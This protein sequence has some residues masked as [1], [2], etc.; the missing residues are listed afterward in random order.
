MKLLH[1]FNHFGANILT[2]NIN[3]EDSSLEYS[4]INNIVKLTNIESVAP[5]KTVSSTVTR[6]ETTSSRA[7]IIATTSDYMD[8]TNLT[9]SKRKITF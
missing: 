7:S 8:V 1:K 6:G 5:Y 2:L 4:Q 9:I 3:T